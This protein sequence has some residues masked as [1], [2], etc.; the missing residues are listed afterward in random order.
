LE[1]IL[2]ITYS[3]VVVLFVGNM[4]SGLFWKLVADK[5]KDPKIISHTFKGIFYSDIVITIPTLLILFILNIVVNSD[6]YFLYI[7]ISINIIVAALCFFGLLIFFLIV[8]PIRM[9]LY[10]IATHG[11]H[12]G[13]FDKEEYFRLSNKWTIYGILELGPLISALILSLA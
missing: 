7:P 3:L 10:Y 6:K 12:T 13:E 9:K 2:K 8:H 4:I 1:N 5:T 11:Y